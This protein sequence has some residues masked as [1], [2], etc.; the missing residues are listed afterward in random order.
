MRRSLPFILGAAVVAVL[1]IGLLQTSSGGEKDDGPKFSL[2]A[3]LAQL[4]GAPE[5]LAALHDQPSELLPEAEFKT[6]LKALKGHPV[7][8]NKWAAW[9]GPCRAEFP[10]F[11]RL[12]TRLGKDVAFV[13]LNSFDNRDNAEEFLGSF[14]V[15]YPSFVDPDEK[16]A[17]SIGAPT[18]FPITVFYRAD[19]KRAY[20][21]QGP[22]E[23]DADLLADIE[24]YAR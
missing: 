23:T 20:V 5:P 1:V 19:G 12:S 17:R 7:V 21:H 22:Y 3:A 18:I 10:V 14:P 9:C 11:Q 8:V 13:G 2:Q 24:R 6:R 16:L 4:K 15:P